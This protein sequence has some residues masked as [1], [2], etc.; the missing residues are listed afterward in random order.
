MQAAERARRRHKDHA[1]SARARLG[2]LGVLASSAP[3]EARCRRVLDSQTRGYSKLSLSLSLSL[4]LCGLIT[5]DG[6]H[7]SIRDGAQGEA[8]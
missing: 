2:S 5:R 7:L 8:G 3:C 6:A 4:A 1:H